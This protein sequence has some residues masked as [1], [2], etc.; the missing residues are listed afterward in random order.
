MPRHIV[1][2]ILAAKTAQEAAKDDP[3]K[4]KAL[5]AKKKAYIEQLRKQIDASTDGKAKKKM[6]EELDILSGQWLGWLLCFGSIWGLLCLQGNIAC[7]GLI[8][9]GIYRFFGNSNSGSG[10]YADH[11]DED[12]DDDVL[13]DDDEKDKNDP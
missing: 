9:Y 7:F 10:D 3:E 13:E 4:Q 5:E 12:D 2:R 11:N 6:Q 1:I 8:C